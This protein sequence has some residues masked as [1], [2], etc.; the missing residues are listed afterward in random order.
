MASLSLSLGPKTLNVKVT[1]GKTLAEVL[2]EFAQKYDLKPEDWTLAS[3][4]KQLDL[5]LPYRLSGLPQNAKLEV[6]RRAN[7]MCIFVITF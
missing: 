1:P 5:S 3:K 2:Q 7:S 6:V 4:G